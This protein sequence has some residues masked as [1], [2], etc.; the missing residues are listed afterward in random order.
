MVL[1]A[2]FIYSAILVGL[3]GQTLGMTVMDVRVVT[4]AY[5]R[6]TIVRSF[7][8][9][10]VAFASSLT[11]VAFVGLFMRIHPH[12]RVSGTRLVRARRAR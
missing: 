12:D 11:A 1:L 4:T 10:I 6:P 2:F 5:R 7:W 3:V 8:R 9:Y